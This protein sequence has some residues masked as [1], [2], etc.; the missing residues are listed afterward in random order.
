MTPTC[1]SGDRRD[2]LLA[3]LVLLVFVAVFIIPT[4]MGWHG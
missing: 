3:A 4:A 2:W 1:R